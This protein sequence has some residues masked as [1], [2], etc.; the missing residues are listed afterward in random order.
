MAIAQNI[1]QREDFGSVY[2]RTY[3]SIYRHCRRLCRSR[4]DAEDVTQEAYS[5]ALSAYER[6]RA[7]RPVENWLMRIATN[8]SIDANRRASHRPKTVSESAQR[9]GL[10]V[11]TL[12]DPRPGPDAIVEQSLERE[13][14]CKAI[15]S[16]EVKSRDLARAAFIDHTSHSAIAKRHNMNKNTLRSRLFRARKAIREICNVN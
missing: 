9:K 14:L 8:A 4:E 11:N 3:G 6:F 13:T 2:T 1:A 12:E 15:D 7:D 5:R 16:F 10:D